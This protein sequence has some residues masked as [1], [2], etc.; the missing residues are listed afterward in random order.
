MLTENLDAPRILVVE[1]DPA[2]AELILRSFDSASEPYLL[3][4]VTTLSSAERCIERHLPSIVLTDYYLPDGRGS[5]L[6]LRAAGAWPVIILSSHGNEKT[7][8][9][10]MKI[11]AIDY[12]TMSPETIAGLPYTVSYSLMSWALIVARRQADEAALRAKKDWER[13]FDAVPELIMI[14][15]SHHAILRVNKNMADR[16]GIPAEELIGRPCFEVI[17]AQP[18]SSPGCAIA[19]G[20]TGSTVFIREIHG[21]KING[22]FEVTISPLSDEDEEITAFVHV[23]R[24]ITEQKK[25]ELLVQQRLKYR[26]TALEFDVD[27]LMQE[28]LDV[29]ALLTDS[30]VGALYLVDEARQQFILQASASTGRAL[31][32]RDGD[33]VRIPFSESGAW[34]VSIQSHEPVIDNDT[35]AHS[36]RKGVF[37]GLFAENYQLL[38]KLTVPIV[39]NGSVVSII[40]VANK[41]LPYTVHDVY[42]VK[43]FITFASEVIERKKTMNA[44]KESEEKHRKL[45]NE[46]RIIL[47]STSVGITFMKNKRLLWANPA[48]DEMF[49][50]DTGATQ[51]LEVESLYADSETC[52]V[53]GD[54]GSVSLESGCMFSHDFMMKK[55]DGAVIWCNLVGHGINP[56]DA[57]EGSIWIFLD[58]TERKRAAEERQK[59]EEQF[60]YTQK[61]ESLGVLAGGIAH[62][63]NNILTVILG[64]CYIVK[65]DFDSGMTVTEHVA[66]IESAANRAADLC[67]QMLAYAGRNTQIHSK[68]NLWLLVEEVVTMLT[69]AIKKNVSIQMDI[70]RDIPEISGEGS[71]IQQ[72]IMN[73]IINGAEAIGDQYGSV[74]VGLGKT[75]VSREQRIVDFMDKDI[76]DGVYA[77]LTVSDT[78][79]GF[80]DEIKVRIFEPFFTTKFAGRGL[81]MS[82]VLGI[83]TS[84]GGALQLESTPGVGST[85]TVYLPLPEGSY[86]SNEIIKSEQDYNASSIGTI[87]LVDDEE[88]LLSIGSALLNAMGYSVLTAVN[89]HDAVAQYQE[90]SREIDAILLDLIMP[91]MGGAETYHALR[92]L[93]PE[94]LIIICSGYDADAALELTSHDANA[95]FLNKP[96]DPVK[97]RRALQG[98]VPA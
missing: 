40:G 86:N 7:A 85:F 96:Y 66:M 11:G 45:A 14:L 38:R 84:H 9:E 59:L 33:T 82:A 48:F 12:V 42:L 27:A 50:Y 35:S 8:V 72:V 23:M 49:G 68:V 29:C 22:I 70:K 17:H 24:D 71:Q 36:G 90:R 77:R 46:Q 39:V 64:H 88:E 6:V 47:N 31:F 93:A 78:G 19:R 37:P 95:L 52:R 15:D 76:P 20:A 3:E 67:R 81:G 75:A 32:H 65:D 60:R 79:C 89:G 74:T 5:E 18:D 10:A 94:K 16:C 25:T 13:T 57:E 4:I 41:T 61:L 21:E 53:V 80:N 62:D 98:L 55:R 83:I 26:D 28:A 87:L 69:S 91:E 63:F 92:A 43:Q 97:L 73:L 34:S 1:D 51:G 30:P 58:I 54:S 2:Q 56:D 44:L